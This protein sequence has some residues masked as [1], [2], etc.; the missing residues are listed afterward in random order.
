MLLKISWFIGCFISNWFYLY[1]YSRIITNQKYKISLKSILNILLFS[2]LNLLAI[3]YVGNLRII[4]TVLLMFLLL[5]S[6][7][8]NS[9]LKTLLGTISIYLICAMSEMLFAVLFLLIFN[10]DEQ[11]FC[12][13]STGVIVSN[14]I[15][16][17][18]S[19]ILINTK[20]IKN[21]MSETFKW[22][23]NNNLVALILFGILVM[24]GFAIFLYQNFLG[25]ISKSYFIMT[26]IAFV[27]LFMIIVRFAKE[28]TNNEKL[29][30]KY[31]NL[32][33]YVK[34]YEKEI[35]EKGKRQH[36]Y[37][38]QLILIKGM[39]DDK[40]KKVTNYIDEMLNDYSKGK[41]DCWMEKLSYIP[42]GGLKGLLHYKISKMMDLKLKVYLNVDINLKS[43]KKWII[44][45]SHQKDISKIIGVYLDNAIEA[46]CES[47]Q[48]Y[49]ILDFD[50]K[51][52]NIIFSISNTYNGVINEIGI[53]KEGY[54]TKG[55]KRGYG[56]SLVKDILCRNFFLE[57]QR[58]FNGPYFVQQLIIKNNVSF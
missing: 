24:G 45:D 19:S 25:I 34:I 17:F 3:F 1:A 38:N 12:R 8:R 23:K 6:T 9:V 28:K 33:D 53:D 7:F 36:E 5:F 39:I 56:L 13:D 11:L 16:I 27:V 35:I 48:K 31:D 58:M 52:G 10:M 44:Y 57:Q 54:S 20:T 32:I 55:Y 40:D 15:I 42:A 21:T 50:Y 41:D 26:N 14:A 22:Y 2:L 29:I 4:F 46:A 30:C 43:R 37:K 47:T 18:I 49:L 51:D